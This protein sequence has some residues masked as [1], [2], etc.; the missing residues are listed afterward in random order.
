MT[1]AE[2]YIRKI[3]DNY[4]FNHKYK[5]YSVIPCNTG[6]YVLYRCV[7]LEGVPLYLE[8]GENYLKDY[9]SKYDLIYRLSYGNF[10]DRKKKLIALKILYES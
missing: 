4:G 7:N 2:K 1:I 5:V 3:Y 9:I 6:W 10:N 8:S